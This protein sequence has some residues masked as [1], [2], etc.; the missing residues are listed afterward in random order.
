M[1]LKEAVSSLTGIAGNWWRNRFSKEKLDICQELKREEKIPLQAFGAEIGVTVGGANDNDLVILARKLFC[2]I[3]SIY[4]VDP[5]VAPY[6]EFMKEDSCPRAIRV[7]KR[8]QDVEPGDLPVEEYRLFESF[9]TAQEHRTDEDKFAFFVAI[10]AQMKG[11]EYLLFGDEIRTPGWWGYRYNRF[12]HYFYNSK[13]LKD[14]FRHIIHQDLIDGYWIKDSIEEYQA[15]AS[16][17]GLEPVEDVARLYHRGSF[18]D[19]YFKP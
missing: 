17:A 5:N 13:G 10:A 18:V 14:F 12:L 3:R 7:P 1:I 8:I 9:N 15:I 4:S 16:R 11:G 2:R 19:M 6:L